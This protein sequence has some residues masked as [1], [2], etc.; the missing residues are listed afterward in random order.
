[1]FNCRAKTQIHYAFVFLGQN[2][3]FL[4]LYLT[5]IN[6]NIK[7][8]NESYLLTSYVYASANSTL[9]NI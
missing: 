1:M 9:K 7:T 6:G 8:Y 3:Y 5:I 2:V 4:F